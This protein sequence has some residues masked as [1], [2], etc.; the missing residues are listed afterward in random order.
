MTNTYPGHKDKMPEGDMA[1]FKN[2]Q[3]VPIPVQAKQIHEPFRVD[4]LEGDYAEGKAGDYLMCGVKGELYIC[5]RVI[6]NTKYR[7]VK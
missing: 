3:S 2:Y 5:D 7:E 4:S 1:Y 6:F